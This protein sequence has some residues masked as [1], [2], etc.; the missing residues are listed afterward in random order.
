MFISM[1]K[2]GWLRIV[3]ASVAIVIILTVL[4]ILSQRARAL[5]S[6]EDM[7]NKAKKILDEI[8]STHILRESIVLS[9]KSDATK[10]ALNVFLRD[11]IPNT[12]ISYELRI[13]PLNDVCGKTEYTSEE[14]YAAERVISTIVESSG[15][16][17]QKIKLFLW[18]AK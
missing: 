4:F 1:N 5:Q 12:G 3:E 2:R 9:P 10:T 17:P 6:S 8:A 15:Y 18:R 11:R 13:C 16:G 7:T 14:V